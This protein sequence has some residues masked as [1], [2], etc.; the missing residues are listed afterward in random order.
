MEGPGGDATVE[1]GRVRV[2][3][4]QVEGSVRCIALPSR[5]VVGFNKQ[6][7]LNDVLQ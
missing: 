3:L 1:V 2:L 6:K 7:G 4:H 5:F